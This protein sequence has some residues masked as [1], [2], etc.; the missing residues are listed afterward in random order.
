MTPKL[1]LSSFSET[2]IQDERILTSAERALLKSLLQN[3]RAAA[4]RN[5]DVQTAIDAA[6]ASALGETIAQRAYSVLGTSIVQQILSATADHR[7]EN[8]GLKIPDILLS[9]GPPPPPAPSPGPPGHSPI[10]PAPAPSS[11]APPGHGLL[12]SRRVVVATSEP[13]QLRSTLLANTPLA[14]AKCVILD[15][16]LSAQETKELFDFAIAHEKDFRTSEVL[17]PAGGVVDYERRRSRVL[18]E[19][20]AYQDSILDRIRPVLP[21][22]FEQMGM[23]PQPTVQVEAQITASNDG[24]AF[25]MH[26]D[27]GQSEIASRYLTFVY[28]FH[29]D[30]A[31]FQGGELRLYDTS[32]ER[33]HR[34]TAGSY[35]VIVPQSNQIVFFPSSLLHEVSEVHCASR[36]FADSRFTLNG[37]LH[38]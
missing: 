16:F 29:R 33:H 17:S 5:P 24:D 15:E 11:P 36:A 1:I 27:D 35:H 30:P 28:F 21:E 25:S 14:T 38:R 4:Q 7:T 3:I 10:S 12:P 37:W 19:V 20:G 6:I 31:A 13:D 23:V 9:P 2:L 32:W 18:V 22:V 8:S 34:S 26:T